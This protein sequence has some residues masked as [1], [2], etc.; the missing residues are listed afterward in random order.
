MAKVSD[1]GASRL[2]PLDR[3]QITTLV[4]GTLGYLDPEYFHTGQLT[5]KSDVYSFG[6]I[7]AEMITGQRPLSNERPQSEMNLAIYFLLKMNDGK[8][9]EILE[10]RVKNEGK[11]EHVEAIA[12][13]ARRCLKLK[14]EERPTMRE[15]SAEIERVRRPVNNDVRA[16]AA[17]LSAAAAAEEDG[18]EEEHRLL[19]GVES[20]ETMEELSQSTRFYSSRFTRVVSLETESPTE[21]TR[22]FPASATGDESLDQHILWSLEMQR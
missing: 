3:A 8:L 19:R 22:Y 11:R 12:E 10:Q 18:E 4:I 17:S 9:Q 16:T 21:E 14:G 7:L 2:I 6:V 1:F 5:E 20:N 15:V 13:L